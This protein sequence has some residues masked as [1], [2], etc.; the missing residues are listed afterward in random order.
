MANAT[1]SVQLIPLSKGRSSN[2]ASSAWSEQKGHVKGG[3]SLQFT[4]INQVDD[5][6]PVQP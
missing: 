1:V 4:V 5:P 2:M 6:Q 3:G